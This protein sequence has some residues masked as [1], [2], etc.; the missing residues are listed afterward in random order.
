MLVRDVAPLP[1]VELAAVLGLPAQQPASA[2][3]MGKRPA[4]IVAAVRPSRRLPRR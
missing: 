4:L 1:V 3:A 2:P